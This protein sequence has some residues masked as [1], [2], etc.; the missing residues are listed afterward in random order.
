MA[1]LRWVL[2]RGRGLRGFRGFRVQGL[3]GLGAQG[4]G[5]GVGLGVQGF[6]V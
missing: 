1:R 2:C 3:G 6:R 4:L 5:L